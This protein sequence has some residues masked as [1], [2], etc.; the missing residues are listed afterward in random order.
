MSKLLGQK[1]ECKDYP[2]EVGYIQSYNPVN[3]KMKIL[4]T[5]LGIKK[6]HISK[7]KVVQ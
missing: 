4:F 2:N 3:G 6:T 7:C 1:V 5:S